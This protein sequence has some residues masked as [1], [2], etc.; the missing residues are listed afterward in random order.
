M[1]AVCEML[2]RTCASD[3]IEAFLD[4]LGLAERLHTSFLAKGGRS[5]CVV[6]GPFAKSSG[7]AG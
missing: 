4:G 2:G 7:R 1:T 6:V 3:E 5:A